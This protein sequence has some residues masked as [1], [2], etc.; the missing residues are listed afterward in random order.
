MENKIKLFYNR[1]ERGKWKMEK[2]Q[3]RIVFMGTPEIAAQTL[4][5]LLDSHFNVV[6]VVT[7]P[8]KQTGRN[9]KIENTPVKTV[10]LSHSIPVFQPVKIRDNFTFLN[11]LKPDIIITF[12]YGQIL[13]QA[14]LDL[15]RYGCLNL[16]GSI[17]PK[18]RGASPVQTAL[19]NGDTL[20]GMTLMKMAAKMDTGDIIK[21]DE[22]RIEETDNATSLFSKMQK[23]AD[24]LLLENL[25]DYCNSK[26]TPIKQNDEEATYCHLIKQDSEKLNLSLPVNQL[27]GWIRGLSFEPGGYLMFE[28]RK[29]KILA[30]K[31]VD[32][33]VF[34][35]IGM[36]IQADKNGLLIQ[37]SDGT[38]SIEL[39][40]LEGKKRMDYKSFIN[41]HPHLLHRFVQ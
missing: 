39:L 27:V 9:R 2:E 37:G 41:G 7:Q 32:Y 36:I 3:L 33:T 16:H 22:I 20:S 13:P 30:A 17:L 21:I 15:P 34:Y 35:P 25:L 26:I 11:E 19:I 6:G 14:L 28:D 18:Y 29:L 23:S 10:A 40:Q 4:T 38:I 24:K 8:D 12:S 5:T 31:V 1:L